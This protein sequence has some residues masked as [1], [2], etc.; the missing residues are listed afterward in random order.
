MTQKNPLT[1]SKRFR[2]FLPIVIDVETA[3]L[4]ANTDALLEIAALTI[5][6]DHQ[7]E[8]YIDQCFHEHIEPFADANLDP[9]ALAFNNIDPFQAL[10]FARPEQ[11]AL[12]HLFEKLQQQISHY[13][14]QRGILVGHNAW[15][16]LSFIQAACARHQ[17]KSPLHQFTTLDTAT[18]GAL[19]T[20]QTVLIKICQALKIEFNPH[21]A[22]SALYDAQ[23]TAELFCKIHNQFPLR[24]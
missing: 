13:H 3:G 21:E 6:L 20:G 2:G 18:L 17:L 24:L 15:F 9:K 22:H 12:A 19:T 11:E 10:R 23:K 7:E 14:C 4:N 5:G 16:D 8:L 1:I